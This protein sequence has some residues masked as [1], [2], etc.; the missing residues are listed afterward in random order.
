MELEN[1]NPHEW[2][3]AIMADYDGYFTCY[4]ECHPGWDAVLRGFFGTVRELIPE[5]GEFKLFQVK[6]KFGELRLYYAVDGVSDEVAKAVGEAYVKANRASQ[7]TCEIT[8]EP[9]SL[10]DRG[11]YLCVRCAR[12][13]KSGD[14]ILKA[15]VEHDS[16]EK[17]EPVPAATTLKA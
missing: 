17:A 13:Q 6:E 12:L 9:G 11:G 2:S 8:G 16:D 15:E 7:V 1:V 4:P 3:K 14:V 10:I 5:P